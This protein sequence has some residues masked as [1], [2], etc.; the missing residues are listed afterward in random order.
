MPVLIV[1]GDHATNEFLHLQVRPLAS[2]YQGYVLANTGHFLPIERPKEFA[3][4][5]IRFLNEK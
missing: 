3:S 5:L 2:N 1:T 4:L